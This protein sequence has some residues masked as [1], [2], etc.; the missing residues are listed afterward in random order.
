MW[1][2]LVPTFKVAHCI[3]VPESW[4]VREFNAGGI[5][6]RAD[7]SSVTLARCCAN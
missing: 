7:A 6:S 4:G 1:P 3:K 2:K 5:E